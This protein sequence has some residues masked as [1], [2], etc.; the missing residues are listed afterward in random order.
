MKKSLL[1]IIVI[2]YVSTNSYSQLFAQTAGFAGKFSMLQNYPD[3]F[4]NSTDI[5]FILE[6]DC[7]VKLFVI[8]VPAGKRTYLVDGE[9]SEGKHGIIFKADKNSKG[10]SENSSNYLCTMQVYSLEQNILIY[11]AEIKMVQK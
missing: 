3:P 8:N 4:A 10:T 7:Y 1:L 11:T 5:K 2:I 9:M 6:E